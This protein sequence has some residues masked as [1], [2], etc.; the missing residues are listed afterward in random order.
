VAR[1]TRDICANRLSTRPSVAHLSS[2]AAFAPLEPDELAET[3][4][5]SA[6]DPELTMRAN[7]LNLATR[8]SGNAR[9]TRS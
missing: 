8:V 5:R 3:R 4:A 2:N 6:S 9:T 1:K 7:A